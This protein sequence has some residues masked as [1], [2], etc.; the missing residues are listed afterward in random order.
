MAEY[1][2]FP[3]VKVSSAARNDAIDWELLL[4][5]GPIDFESLGLSSAICSYNP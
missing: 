1:R 3:T 4:D 2:P 5:P